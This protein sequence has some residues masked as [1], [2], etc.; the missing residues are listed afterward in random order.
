MN[1]KLNDILTYVIY[2]M[3]GS[4]KDFCMLVCVHYITNL[5]KGMVN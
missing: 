1:R 3:I 4:N 5:E 2:Y